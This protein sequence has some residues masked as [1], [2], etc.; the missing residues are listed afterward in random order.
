HISTQVSNTN[1]S[2]NSFV[3]TTRSIE[4]VLQIIENIS[5]QTHL[6]ALNAS[7]EAARVGEHGKGFAVVASEI[8]K[9]SESTRSSVEQIQ[10]IIAEVYTGAAHAQQS[11][12]EGNRVVTEGEELV[13]AAT[14]LLRQANEG[15]G[16]KAKIIDEV[17]SLMEN[18]TAVSIGNRKLSREAEEQVAEL[19]RDFLLV[20]QASEDVESI[21][22]FL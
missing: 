17:V 22:A 4:D 19:K 14:Q 5:S 6:L 12:E 15:E 11:M 2:I 1:K 9:L 16:Q 8:R 20:Q 21:A 3:E 13:A 10:G 7:I 18:I